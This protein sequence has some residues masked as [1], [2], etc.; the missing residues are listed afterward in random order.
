MS[1]PSKPKKR[2]RPPPA[3]VQIESDDPVIKEEIDAGLKEYKL[4]DK[5]REIAEKLVSF[6]L[7]TD[8]HLVLSVAALARGLGENV[9]YIRK[10]FR[11][12]DFQRYMMELL[13]N[14]SIVQESLFWRGMAIGLGLGDPQIMRLYAQVS[15]K[16]KKEEKKETTK[17]VIVGPDGVNIIPTTSIDADGDII[18]VEQIGPGDD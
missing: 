7:D 15:G 17:I 18:D 5:Q 10:V 2:K 12:P 16:I 11:M 14:E 9:H 6:E 3:P 1:K 13:G 8:S 4:T